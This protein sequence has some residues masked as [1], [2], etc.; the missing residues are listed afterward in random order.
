MHPSHLIS[1]RYI[2]IMRIALIF[3]M[4]PLPSLAWEFSPDPICTLTHSAPDAD[5]VITYNVDLPEYTL[6]IILR[7]GVWADTDTFQLIFGGG[8]GGAIGTT[9]QAISGDGTTLTVRD[10]GFGNVLDGLEFNR[11]MGVV[12]DAQMMFDVALDDAVPAVR[13]FRA[14]PDDN[15]ALS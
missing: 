1:G 15:P 7:G 12:T 14:C 5:I 8:R 2:E 13:A 3:A 10:S 4:M 6:H 11:R 9:Q